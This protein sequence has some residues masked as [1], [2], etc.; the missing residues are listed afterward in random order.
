MREHYTAYVI[1]LVT[2]TWLKCD[3]ENVREVKDATDVIKEEG[4]YML[5]YDRKN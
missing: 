2:V 4:A 5:L 1:N 3:D